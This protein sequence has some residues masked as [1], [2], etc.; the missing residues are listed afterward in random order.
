MDLIEFAWEA[1]SGNAFYDGVKSIFGASFE[2][3][4]SFFDNSKKDEFKS[5]VET[6]FSV[7]E[8]IKKQLEELQ[9]KSNIN[10][11]VGKGIGYIETMNGDI[12]F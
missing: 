4:K 7:N 10:I 11:K 5:H 3:L 1:V 6:I 9:N 8:E 12:N 2:K